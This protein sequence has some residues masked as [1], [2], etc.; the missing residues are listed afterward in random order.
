MSIPA[1]PGWAR[2]G[3]PALTWPPPPCPLQV[4]WILSTLDQLRLKPPPPVAIL[5]LGT[6]NDL[7][8][9]LNWG[10]VSS[11]GRGREPG[12]GERGAR[13][14]PRPRGSSVP[15]SPPPPP[16][17]T[18]TSL[19]PRSCPT[20]RRAMWCSWTAGTSVR[21]P[22]P[23]RGPRSETRGP[24]T[25]WVSR[26]GVLGVSGV[27]GK[28][29]CN[30]TSASPREEGM[31]WSSAHERAVRSLSAHVTERLLP[32]GSAG[33]QQRAEPGPGAHEALRRRVV[34]GV[35]PGKRSQAALVCRRSVGL[36]RS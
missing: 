33:S 1:L 27:W 11:H 34:G 31:V 25:G 32:P 21:S 36:P 24:P 20:W 8:R 9:T 29:S 26:E 3:P 35:R 30:Q 15:A 10:G 12:V 16:R 17:A 6:G 23:R 28:S 4:G 14:G 22:T 2:P 18:P 19:C 5:P 13:G 7:A